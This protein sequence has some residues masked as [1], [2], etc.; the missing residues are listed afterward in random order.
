MAARSSAAASDP[1]RLPP[2]LAAALATVA[3]AMRAAEEPWWLIGS[4]AMALH[5]A[6]VDVD[7][8]DLLVGIDDAKRL[9]G[10]LVAPGQPSDRFRSALFGVWQADGIRV[11]VMAGLQLRDGGC[12]QD[13]VP[14]RRARVTLGDDLLYTPG[15][16]GL[17]E[18]CRLFDRPKDRARIRVLHGL[19]PAG[20]V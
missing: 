13:V 6:A 9:F 4:A 18:L 11:E 8:I 12:W 20:D 7:D 3:E 15:L 19:S 10:G 1:A 5:G 16:D 17:I 2:S 14:G